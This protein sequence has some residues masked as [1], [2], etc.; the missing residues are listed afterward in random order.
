MRINDSIITE[1]TLYGWHASTRAT[2]S[3]YII[4]LPLGSCKVAR[5]HNILFHNTCLTLMRV[6][7]ICKELRNY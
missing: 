3:K 7:F 5:Y 1:V 4:V 2:Q 6:H